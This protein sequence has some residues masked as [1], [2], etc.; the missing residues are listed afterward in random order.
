MSGLSFLNASSRCYNLGCNV[1]CNV[2]FVQVSLDIE[3]AVGDSSAGLG[4]IMDDSMIDKL[5]NYLL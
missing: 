5:G 1:S 4:E 2:T 3:P